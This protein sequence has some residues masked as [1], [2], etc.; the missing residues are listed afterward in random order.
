MSLLVDL[1]GSD[2]PAVQEQA[3][4][5]LQNLANGLQ[6]NKDAIIVAGFVAFELR[7]FSSGKPAVQEAAHALWGLALVATNITVPVA[8]AHR[9]RSHTW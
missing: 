1:L 7:F 9:H 4:R 2:K 6:Q 3:A 8:N 5:A